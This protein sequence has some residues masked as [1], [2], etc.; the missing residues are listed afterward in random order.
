MTDRVSQVVNHS[1][2]NPAA[3][4]F[5]GAYGA[6]CLFNGNFGALVSQLRIDFLGSDNQGAFWKWGIA[7]LILYALASN[8]AT[9][10]IFGP[11]L[12]IAL[13]AMLVQSVE[14]NPAQFNSFIATVRSTFAGGTQASVGDAMA[15]IG[16]GW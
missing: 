7:L 8:S 10:E 11:V 14:K 13:A 9:N 4:L 3:L 1:Y 5:I 2:A 12:I 6:I 15:G 16:S